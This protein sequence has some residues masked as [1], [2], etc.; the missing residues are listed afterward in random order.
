MERVNLT[1][2]NK[3]NIEGLA[4]SGAFDNFPEITREQF[5]ALNHKGET[6]IDQLIRYGNKFQL[7]K[8]Q[9]TNSL[10]GD[11]GFVEISHPDIPVADRW[12]DLERLNKERELTG[13][14]LSAHPS[15]EYAIILQLV[16]N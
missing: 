15:D 7:D 16:C 5:F 3:K 14:Y 2:C 11:D 9:A 12:T 6:F 13:I 10:F 8:A 1:A 4:L